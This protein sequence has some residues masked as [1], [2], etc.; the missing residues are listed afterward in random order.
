MVVPAERMTGKELRDDMGSIVND[1]RGKNNLSENGNVKPGDLILAP[2]DGFSDLPF[3]SICR[4]LG[5]A[6]SYTGFINTLDILQ[7]H[8]RVAQ[9]LAFL[10]EERPVV[11]QI[12]DSV[13]KATKE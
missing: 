13:A 7:G 1:D 9:K 4:E 11:F 12:F 3:R 10:P 5:S 6:M 8:P 2:M